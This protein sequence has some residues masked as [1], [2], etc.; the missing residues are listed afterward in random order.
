LP[1]DSCRI[2]IVYGV[3]DLAIRAIHDGHSGDVHGFVRQALALRFRSNANSLDRS[4]ERNHQLLEQQRIP[5]AAEHLTEERAAAA[6]AEAQQR[7]QQV[8][9]SLQA[10]AALP[11][12]PRRA[13]RPNPPPPRHLRRP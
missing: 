1:H 7:V 6:V 3:R 11:N 2:I 8:A 4:A 12:P 10:R 5:A 13:R 9:A